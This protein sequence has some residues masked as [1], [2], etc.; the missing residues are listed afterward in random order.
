M[1]AHAQVAKGF[2]IDKD[3]KARLAKVY[4]YNPANDEGIYNNAKGEFI[5]KAK[6][7][8]TLFAALPGYMMDTAIYTGTSA[9]VFQLKS[10]SIA[11]NQVEI[12]GKKVSPKEQYEKN[13][14]DYKYMLDKGSSKDLLN[15][16][17]NGVGLGID[18]IYN[19]LS[20]QGRNARHLQSILE[21]DYRE[22]IIDYR[23][24]TDYVSSVL[25][26]NNI[27]I[28]D[29]ML[30]YRPTYQFVLTANDYDFVQFIQKSY[31]SYQR[32]PAAFRLPKLPKLDSKN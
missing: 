32:N 9:V 2:V 24:N 31:Q 6:L 4:I 17:N 28:K 3:N 20:R 10:L 23:Y 14:K 16:S 13:L 25:S 19:L 1:P 15:M 12:F 22:A 27:D 29:F 7:G 8:D 5:I 11:L 26:N 21:K 18:A 30:Q